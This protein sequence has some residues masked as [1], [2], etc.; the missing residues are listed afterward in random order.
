MLRRRKILDK[1]L[2]ILMLKREKING[3]GDAITVENIIIVD[4]KFFYR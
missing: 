1:N 2:R 3:L 4:T